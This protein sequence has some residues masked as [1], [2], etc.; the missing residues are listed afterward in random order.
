MFHGRTVVVA[1]AGPGLGEEVARIVLREGGNAV[2]GARDEERVRAIARSLDPEGARTLALRCDI[3]SAPDCEG[4]VAAALER[5][6][7]VDGLA[8]VAARIDV[9]G[10]IETTAIDGWRAVIETNVIGTVQL[11]QAAIPALKQRGGAVVIV[12]SQSE[13]QPKPAPTFIAYG[14]SKAAM[15]A[16]VIY[17]A[18]QLG[19]AGVRVNRVVPS[20]MWT[21][22]LEGFASHMAKEQGCSLD[23]VK[24]R[25]SADMPLG[26]MPTGAETAEA[27]AFLLSDRAS[28]ITGQAL[29]VNSGEWMA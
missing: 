4:L 1:G 23:D 11:L 19:P 6:G 27:I 8:C 20:T 15:H 21:P 26:R 16:A 18:G 9:H 22:T 24:A 25:F 17:M 13:V 28:A 29:F 5:F 14:A 12:G 7:R 10:S 2:L 3:E